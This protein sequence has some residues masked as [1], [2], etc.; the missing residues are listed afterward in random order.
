MIETPANPSV[1]S[2][3]TTLSEHGLQVG[4][5]RECLDFDEKIVEEVFAVVLRQT[6][7][8]DG[9]VKRI[10]AKRGGKRAERVDQ[11]PAQAAGTVEQQE[12]PAAGSQNAG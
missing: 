1:H 10:I 4:P 2:R 5:L 9:C 7:L 11:F 3:K 8:G 6:G 12:Q